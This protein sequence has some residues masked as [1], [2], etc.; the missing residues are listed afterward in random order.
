M[1]LP[2]RIVNSCALR[3]FT[4]NPI[5]IVL[6]EPDEQ[7]MQPIA[8][9]MN[10]SCSVFPVRTDHHSYRMRLFTPKREV[11]YAGSPSLAAAWSMGQ[12]NWAQTTPGAE[13]IIEVIGD[14]AWMS[15][16]EPVL[17]II[18]DPDVIEGIGL[19]SIE[20]MFTCKVASQR[21]T[22]AV[23][24]D[25]PDGFTPR[26]DI[27]M[28]PALRYGPALVGAVRRESDT[29]IQARFFGPAH[30][31]PEDPAC[32]AAA[33]AVATIMHRYFGTKTDVSL[34]QG[35]Q[36]GRA[37]RIEVS[38]GNVSIRMGGRLVPMAEGVLFAR[39]LAHLSS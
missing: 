39:D 22:I 23:T 20:R 17:E 31:V 28:R 7:L 5:C 1:H 3:V 15:Q 2:Y 29:E 18:D 4:G 36:I 19:R 21:Y 11:G 8:T 16:P 14:V 12:G 26:Q 9:Q 24:N 38:L 33:G 30:G 10:L 27:L 6:E 34:Y 13:A 32:G 37:S 25:D 35:R